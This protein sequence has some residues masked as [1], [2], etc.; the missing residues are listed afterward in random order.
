MKP[1]FPAH[2]AAEEF[3]SVIDGH[4]DDETSDR[5]ASLAAVVTLMRTHEHPEPRPEFASDL[6]SRLL[7]AAESEL[8]PAPVAAPRPPARELRPHRRPLAT[9]AAALVLIGGTAGVAAAAQGSVPGDPL[10]PLKLGIEQASV[11]LHTSD[12]GKGA[13]LLGQASTRLSEAQTLIDDGGSASEIRTTLQSFT[14]TADRGAGLLFSSY[15]G[16]GDDQSI[17]TVRSFTATQMARLA[18]VAPTAPPSTAGAFERAANTLAEIDQQARVLCSACSEAAS[19][20]VPH[21]LIG[22]SSVASL[23]TL[24]QHPAQMA[25]AQARAARALAAAAE[26]ADRVAAQ[27][28]PASTQQPPAGSLPG[29]GSTEKPGSPISVA[30]GDQPVRDLVDGVTS[31]TGGLTNGLSD[32]V[33][34]VTS[35]VTDGVGTALDGSGSDEGG[36]DL[37]STVDKTVNGLLGG[38]TGP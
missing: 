11:A 35:K 15:Q 8:V 17:T 34:G 36:N 12:S 18:T 33:N 14:S 19:L 13:D 10:Y 27:Q 37:G 7:L 9:A 32:A 1:L 24:I 22:P 29:T 2:R 28:P 21:D 4:P 23:S 38:L 6:R 3:A 26:A 30:A 25:E 5:Y 16:S 31:K 20:S